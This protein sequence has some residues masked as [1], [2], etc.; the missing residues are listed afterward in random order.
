VV[1][2]FRGTSETEKTHAF[3]LHGLQAAA[4]YEVRF[5]DAGATRT[6]TGQQLLTGGLN[7][8]LDIPNSSELIFIESK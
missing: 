5:H 1:Y 7:V 2:A 4:R 6:V 3:V 8:R